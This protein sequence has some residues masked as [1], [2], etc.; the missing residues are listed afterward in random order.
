MGYMIA[1]GDYDR[2]VLSRAS[3]ADVSIVVRVW[4]ECLAN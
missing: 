3:D 1:R 4:C 2:Y